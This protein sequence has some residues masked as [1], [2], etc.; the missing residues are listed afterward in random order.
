LSTSFTAEELEILKA[1]QL[2]KFGA[3]IAK[4]KGDRATDV[5]RLRK[6]QLIRYILENSRYI[7][8]ELA[9][10]I[11]GAIEERKKMGGRIRRVL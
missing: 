3:A 10:A 7:S 9:K 4:V 11:R 1:V 8:D 5:R 6:A 2:K